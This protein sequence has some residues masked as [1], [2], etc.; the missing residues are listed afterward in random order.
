MQPPWTEIGRLETD[1][2]GI[3][4]T[5][6]QKANKYEIHQTNSTMDSLQHTIRKLSA[7]LDGFRSE[8]EILREEI[9]VL[10]EA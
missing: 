9:R 10:K 8:L 7:T 6:N 1:V 3:Q 5:L 2:R 4:S